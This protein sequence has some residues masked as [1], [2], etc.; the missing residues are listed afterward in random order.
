[1]NVADF[2][3]LP[4]SNDSVDGFLVAVSETE[5][6]TFVNT[7]LSVLHDSMQEMD[8]DGGIAPT[9]GFLLA[10]TRDTVTMG[11]VPVRIPKPEPVPD[12]VSVPGPMPV[13]DP[14]PPV[15]NLP[16][17]RDDRRKLFAQA[18]ERRLAGS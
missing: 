2:Y 12:P 14:G 3:D 13:P 6:E 16:M 10:M 5:S 15:T 18:C 11:T 1:M 7:L 17:T 9:Y 8:E 4:L